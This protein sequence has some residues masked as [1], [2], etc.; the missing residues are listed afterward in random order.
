[1]P[2]WP[3]MAPRTV[4]GGVWTH[5]TSVPFFGDVYSVCVSNGASHSNTVP[6]SWA[7][8]TQDQVFFMAMAFEAEMRFSFMLSLSPSSPMQ[9]VPCFLGYVCCRFGLRHS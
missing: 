1:V 3:R 9:F 2:V 4:F 6:L 5:V 7:S 8:S